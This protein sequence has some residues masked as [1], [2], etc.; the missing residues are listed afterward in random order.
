MIVATYKGY[1]NV[2]SACEE[3][4]TACGGPEGYDLYKC[5]GGEWVLIERNS[6]ECGYIPVPPFPCPIACVCIGTPLVD[7]LGPIREFRDR[8]LKTNLLGQRLVSFYYGVLTLWLPPLLMRHNRIKQICRVFIVYPLKKLCEK[9][10]KE[11]D[12]DNKGVM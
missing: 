3:G 12:K 10:I 11:E 6:P 4:E 9:F 1:L 5:I 8:Y 7:E 2:Q